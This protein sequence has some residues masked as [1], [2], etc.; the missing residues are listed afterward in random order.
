MLTPVLSK[1][2]TGSPFLEQDSSH[3]ETHILIQNR[4][5]ICPSWKPQ[6]IIAAFLAC[7]K[8][9]QV[10]KLPLKI[11]DTMKKWGNELIELFQKK[12]S[13]WPKYT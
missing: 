3:R 13:K 10:G 7:L 11:N 2:E 4:I 1:L 12:K 8:E 9:T 6:Y 5:P